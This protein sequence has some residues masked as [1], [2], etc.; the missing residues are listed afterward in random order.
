MARL[1]FFPFFSS[2]YRTSRS[3]TG[4]HDHQRRVDPSGDSLRHVSRLQIVHE[5]FTGQATIPQNEL[6]SSLLAD[7]YGS[8][9]SHA[10]IGSVHEN[11]SHQRHDR[12]SRYS[13]NCQQGKN[14]KN[15]SHRIFNSL[16]NLKKND[17]K[18]F[19]HD[20]FKNY[21]RFSFVFS[22]KNT[23]N[24][25]ICFIYKKSGFFLFFENFPVWKMK[26]SPKNDKKIFRDNR[27]KITKL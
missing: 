14:L 18:H 3:T 10:E 12:Y 7:A 23:K 6:S 9:P 17:K 2:F 20:F 11:L 19:R 4:P 5:K 13:Q 1:R 22:W 8:Y 21:E 15:N 24:S 16:E 25:R 26:K 27:M